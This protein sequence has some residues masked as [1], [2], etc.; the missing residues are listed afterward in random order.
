MIKLNNILTYMSTAYNCLSTYGVTLTIESS[1]Q[2]INSL[3]LSDLPEQIR[4]NIRYNYVTE[5]EAMLPVT[6]IAGRACNSCL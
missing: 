3:S 5:K 4:H 1:G 2:S 6:F